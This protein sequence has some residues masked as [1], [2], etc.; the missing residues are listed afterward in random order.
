MDDGSPIPCFHVGLWQG[1]SVTS[2]AGTPKIANWET[3]LKKVKII[4]IICFPQALGLEAR[5]QR[6][7]WPHMI[8]VALQSD[9]T[10]VS[11]GQFAIPVLHSFRAYR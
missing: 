9:W 2:V 3:D 1:L 10:A 6:S 4:L 8:G 5:L 11:S 7:P